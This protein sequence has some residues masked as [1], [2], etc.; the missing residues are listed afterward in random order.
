MLWKRDRKQEKFYSQSSGFRTFS[1][2]GL[3]TRTIQSTYGGIWKCGG[4][5]FKNCYDDPGG[6]K[7]G[8]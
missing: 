5:A 7:K 3:L 2:S 1:E 6:E 8:Y 4:G